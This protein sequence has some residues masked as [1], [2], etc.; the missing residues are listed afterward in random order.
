ME[1]FTAF[2]ITIIILSVLI[3]GF[4]LFIAFYNRKRYHIKTIDGKTVKVTDETCDLLVNEY[5]KIKQKKSKLNRAKRDKLVD[6]VD[7]LVK[8]GRIRKSQ[9]R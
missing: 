9:L 7:H 6:T 8:I 2:Q 3:T 4:A 1:K 5:K